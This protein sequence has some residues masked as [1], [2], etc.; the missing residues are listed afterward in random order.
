MSSKN[1]ELS[2][3]LMTDINVVSRLDNHQN[4][5]NAIVQLQGMN[6]NGRE[7]KVNK[8][9]SITKHMSF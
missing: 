4:A 7:A 6:V 9:M 2:F 5:A 8:K 1:I 3:C